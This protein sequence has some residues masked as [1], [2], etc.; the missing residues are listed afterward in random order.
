[1]GM[2]PKRIQPVTAENVLDA[3]VHPCYSF[4]GDPHTVSPLHGAHSLY[5]SRHVFNWFAT[6]DVLLFATNFC[7][8]LSRMNVKSTLFFVPRATDISLNKYPERKVRPADVPNASRALQ[9]HRTRFAGPTQQAT[10]TTSDNAPLFSVVCIHADVASAYVLPLFG[11]QVKPHD[12]S[13]TVVHTF[14][15]SLCVGLHDGWDVVF[16]VPSGFVVPRTVVANGG[17]GWGRSWGPRGTTEALK[18]RKPTSRSRSRSRSTKT[19]TEPRRERSGRGFFTST[20]RCSKI[21]RSRNRSRSRSG[22]NRGKV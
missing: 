16:G 22:S 9:T 15:T 10:N 8:L 18:R 7:S 1:L 13:T 4:L 14:L 6:S 5:L 3:M 20:H 21:K 17:W 12:L 19:E 11:L 2:K